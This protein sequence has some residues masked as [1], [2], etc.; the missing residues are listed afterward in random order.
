M[1]TYPLTVSGFGFWV[2]DFFSGRQRGSPDAIGRP[3]TPGVRRRNA[4]TKRSGARATILLRP[5][6]C[7]CKLLVRIHISIVA[8]CAAASRCCLASV[9]RSVRDKIRL[10][11]GAVHKLWA[12]HCRWRVAQAQRAATAGADTL[13]GAAAAN[14]VQREAA[15]QVG[16][17]MSAAA[18]GDAETAVGAHMAGCADVAAPER[19]MWRELQE[20]ERRWQAQVADPSQEASLWRRVPMRTIAKVVGRLVSMG[21]AVAPARLMCWDPC[22][23]LYSNDVVDWDGLVE[24]SPEVVAEL[25]WVCAGCSARS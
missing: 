23:A 24:A 4:V 10:P 21:M 14:E 16:Q 2:R 7:S 1:E 9:I 18:V 22:R 13:D 25:K 12:S 15:T 17:D 20:C 5:S 11:Y 19:V 6:P 3:A 8:W